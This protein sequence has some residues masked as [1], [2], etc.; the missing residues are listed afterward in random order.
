M[1][2][3]YYAPFQSVEQEQLHVDQ[4]AGPLY[5]MPPN[6]VRPLIQQLLSIR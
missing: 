4:D 1:T 5:E 3:K 2:Q 6:T